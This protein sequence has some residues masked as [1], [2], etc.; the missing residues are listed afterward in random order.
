MVG[1]HIRGWRILA[2]VITIPVALTGCLTFSEGGGVSLTP[3]ERA[4]RE[5]A[6]VF[7]Q[8]VLGGA[9]AGAAI[10]GFACMMFGSSLG[11]CA[12]EAAIGAVAGGIAGYVTAS[13]QKAANEQV[14]AT[15]IVTRDIHAENE[16]LASLVATARSVLEENRAS[17]EEL[18]AR[19]VNNEAEAGEIDAQRRKIQSNVEVLNGVIAN[20]NEKR[21]QYTEVAGNLD[22]EG[23][24]TAALRKQV[25]EMSEQLDLLVEYRSALEE[26]LD[27]ELMG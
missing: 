22:D 11:D 8:T 24:D 2:A 18:R 7:N 17:N 27:V 15:D 23:K 9:A 3:E 19:I 10:G 14:R 4:L 21:S 12:A 20:L 1:T 6:Q 16:R 25:R 13:K 26:E 5:E